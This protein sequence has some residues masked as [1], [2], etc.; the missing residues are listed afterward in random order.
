MRLQMDGDTL[1]VVSVDSVECHVRPDRVC[2]IDPVL[3]IDPDL[4]PERD[5][6]PTL[7]QCGQGGPVHPFSRTSAPP[8]PVR[9]C[10]SPASFDR[11]NRMRRSRTAP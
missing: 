4:V 7:Q 3:L 9:S 1:E 6:S 5:Y 10:E 2:G 8:S 11:P